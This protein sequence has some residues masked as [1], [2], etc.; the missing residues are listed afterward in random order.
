[1]LLKNVEKKLTSEP[2]YESCKAFSDHLM[3]IEMRKTSVLMD[4]PIMVG[5]AILDKSKVLRHEFYYDY[6]KPKYH[7]KVKLLYMDTDSFVLPIE[8]EDFFEDIKND[9]HDW[10]GTSKYLKSLNL[11]LEYWINKKIIKK[12]KM[13]YSMDLWKILL[14]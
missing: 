11:L 6:L 5:K 12:W 7:D 13:S 3:A 1:M 10:F 14:Q 8:T 9:I 4:R 2:N